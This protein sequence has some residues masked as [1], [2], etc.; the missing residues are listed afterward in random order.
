MN[1]QA[2]IVRETKETKIELSLNLDGQGI[3]EINTGV[4]FFDHMLTQLAFHGFFDLRLRAS[5]DLEVDFHH[6][7][8]DVGICLG[9]AF[10]K[11]LGDR[12]LIARYGQASVPMDESLASVV[13]DFS[14]R[15]ICV[16]KGNLPGSTGAF[17]GQLAAE[18]WRAFANH[19]GLT[20]HMAFVYGDNNHHQLE[21][22]FKALAKALQMAVS[23]QTRARLH[24]S[25]KGVL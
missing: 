4:G 18:F 13:L 24:A 16:I 17:D 1:R 19:A 14:N 20:L 10:A 3:T 11:C 21:A 7:V 8:E 5:G 2:T 12:S 23:P 6:T 25:T 9:Q 22:A 15:P